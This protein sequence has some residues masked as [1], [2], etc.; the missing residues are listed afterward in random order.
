MKAG[1]PQPGYYSIVTKLFTVKLRRRRHPDPRFEAFPE[2]E[3]T[4]GCVGTTALRNSGPVP[5]V[6]GSWEASPRDRSKGRW[7]GSVERDKEGK[8]V[9]KPIE[10]DEEN[11][12]LFPWSIAHRPFHLLLYRWWT[13]FRC[14]LFQLEVR[15]TL[16]HCYPCTLTCVGRVRAMVR[17]GE[18]VRNKT[19]TQKAAET[20]DS[21]GGSPHRS[22]TACNGPKAVTN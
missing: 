16:P 11:G 15:T 20:K 13:D 17:R 12:Y 4:A 8:S 18:A 5:W 6:G 2:R 7:N 14:C 21:S 22:R 1:R 9:K 3:W 10:R 19:E